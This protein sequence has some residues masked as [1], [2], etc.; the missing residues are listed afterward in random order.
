MKLSFYTPIAYDYKYAIASILSYYEIADEIILAIDKDRISW[1]N[2]KY[3]F[4]MQDFL[5][6]IN[7]I[8][9]HDKIQIFE[10]NFH[11]Y[12]PIHNDTYERNCISMKCKKENYIVGI[13]S[14]EILLNPQEFYDWM[15]INNPKEDVC[16]YWY[17]VY[18]AFESKYLITLPNETTVIGTNLRNTFRKCRFTLLKNI[19]SPLKILHFSWGRKRNEIEQKLQNWSHTQD[20]DIKKYLET[21]DSVS[22][23]NYKEKVNLHP[24]N[25]KQWWQKLELVE[26]ESFGVSEELLKQIRAF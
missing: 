6:K 2:K 13:D 22:L 8:D 17:S 16:C 1:A 3:D 10:D 9:C 15:D 19:Q 23:S 11:L 4:D 20:F 24:L 5:L 12:E 7:Q 26:L 14:D 18:K 25:L 21:W